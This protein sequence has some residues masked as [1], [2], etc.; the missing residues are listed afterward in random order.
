[1]KIGNNNLSSVQVNNMNERLIEMTTKY[2]N[3]NDSE[4]SESIISIQTSP[5][6][7]LDSRFSFFRYSVSLLPARPK[8]SA[9]SRQ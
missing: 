4:N 6:R 2:N 8:D 9:P 1:M 3:A 5:E 7:L